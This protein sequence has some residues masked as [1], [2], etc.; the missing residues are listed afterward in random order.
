MFVLVRLFFF[1]FLFGFLQI[2]AQAQRSVLIYGSIKDSLTLESLP[3]ASIYLTPSLKGAITDANGNYKFRA[4]PGNYLLTASYV[5]FREYK[6]Q[7]SLSENDS[8]KLDISLGSITLSAVEIEATRLEKI[9]STEMGVNALTMETI[10]TM[11]AFLGEV[12]LLKSI[13][14]LPGVQSAGEGSAGFY[15]RGGGPDQN[16]ILFDDA[17]VYNASHL[18]GFFSVFNSDAIQSVKLYKGVMPARH[19]ERLASV[20]DIEQR[21]GNKDKFSGRGGIGL[22]SSRLTLE[23]PIEKGKSTFLIA[24]RRTYIDAL[25]KP[26]IKKSSPFGGSGYYFYDLNARLDWKLN[27]GGKLYLS[28]Y[29][30]DDYF[31]F[32]SPQS[33][34]KTTVGWG[35]RIASGG[36][37]KL[38]NNNSLLKLN[39][40]ITNYRFTFLGAQDDF[41][42]EVKSNVL[43]YRF[44]PEYSFNLGSHRMRF[45]GAYTNHAIRPNNS[46]AEQGGTQFDLGELQK[47]RSHE[48]AI[49][50]SDAFDLTE[51]WS[52]EAGIRASAFMHVGPFTR[53]ILDENGNKTD[54]ISYGKNENIADYFGLEPRFMVRYQLNSRSSIKTAFTQNYQYIHLA[55]ISP[56]A[57]PT[58]V[59]L[60]S[61]D[62][63]Q[64]QLGRQYSLG[65]FRNFFDGML[66]TSVEGYFK[67]MDNLVE[68]KE[69]TQPSDGVDNNEDN[70][71]TF[72]NGI[73]YG[74][75]VF[76][77]KTIGKTTG[78]IGY[79]LSRSERTFEEIN[80]GRTY[81]ATFDRTHD[82][83]LVVAH[84]L[85]K[86][87]TLSGNFIFGTG[88]AITLPQSGYF[89][90]NRLVYNYDER[91]SFRMKDYHRLDLSAI[92]QPNNTRIEIDPKTGNKIE[93]PRKI[94][95]KWVFSIYNVYN[96]LNPYFYY[97]DTAG[98]AVD[99]TYKVTAK[100]VS[101]FP[102][103]PS[104]T[105]N[106]SF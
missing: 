100:Q 22:I 24:G 69:N 89:I 12:D 66:E 52:F 93:V 23:G 21:Q 68:Y 106:F 97:F 105:W 67:T 34:F 5:G 39:A 90:E 84:K 16:L 28:G 92:Y 37:S 98:R 60:P 82:L 103:L 77:H 9:R 73:A 46:R 38:F 87:W 40:S 7:I 44:K 50:L 17:V 25:A 10:E 8:L 2:S 1:F 31:D 95:S 94:Q 54:T 56:L 72:G 43:D 4:S 83:A 48:G 55:N 61:T 53:Y 75:E 29:F 80:Q 101:L 30:G 71:L 45:G 79:T 35:N 62:V 19:G 18:L 86:K 57:L 96:R 36:Y 81:P 13:Q 33:E 76:I 41:E 91:N 11:P 64:P 85:N 3:G 47:Y 51:T 59:W 42:L 88:R 104:V 65:Y 26:F 27:K 74:I 58:D 14:L 15:V 102:I 70:L 32:N 49:Y 20:I 6:K 99:N 63:I 78:W